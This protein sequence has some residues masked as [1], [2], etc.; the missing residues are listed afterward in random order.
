[1]LVVV[2]VNLG[3]TFK[4]SRDRIG[5]VVRPALTVRKHVVCL[6]LDSAKAVA[7]AAPAVALYQK[8]VYVRLL[9]FSGH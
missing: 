1:M 2:T 5:N 3:M 6:N 8:L 4:A 7:D 9:E